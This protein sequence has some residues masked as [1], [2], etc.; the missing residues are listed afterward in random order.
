MSENLW[1]MWKRNV[2]PLYNNKTALY[3]LC[4]GMVYNYRA[5][6]LAPLIDQHDLAAIIITV[7]IYLTKRINLR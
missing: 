2:I 3:K 7:K 1:T 6:V 4:N 5:L